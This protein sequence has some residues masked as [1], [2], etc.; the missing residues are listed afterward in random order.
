[1][2]YEIPIRFY[3]AIRGHYRLNYNQGHM[4]ILLWLLTSWQNNIEMLYF[5]YRG[6]RRIFLGSHFECIEFETASML[7]L[8][9]SAATALTESC[10]PEMVTFTQRGVQWFY[11]SE[12][13][14]S[15]WFFIITWLPNTSNTSWQNKWNPLKYSLRS[16][17]GQRRDVH[18][19]PF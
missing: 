9:R 7:S 3:Q 8:L 12:T 10:P 5:T 18:L 13:S 11:H 16:K 14:C 15:V 2:F 1:M 17:S 19:A 6:R 4:P